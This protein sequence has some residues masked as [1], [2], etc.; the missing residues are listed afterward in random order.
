MKRIALLLVVLSAV[1]GVVSASG[2]GDGEAAPIYG[3]NIPLGYRVWRFI[4]EIEVV[5]PLNDF[6]AKLGN[7]VA[8]KAF[9]EGNLPFPDA[10]IIARLAWRKDTSKEN[11][12]VG[13]LLERGVDKAVVERL[14]AR[15]WPPMN[16]QFMIKDSRKYA[17]T[18]DWGFAQFTDNKPDDEAVHKT[19]FSCHES[20][21]DRDFV[22]T[23]YARR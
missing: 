13:R 7:D 16:V 15:G 9:R 19:C 20:A 1:G 11:S 6:R 12:V 3:V 8:I 17:S 10:T 14:L 23:L 21:K 2:E 18:G 22:F 5:A 4:S